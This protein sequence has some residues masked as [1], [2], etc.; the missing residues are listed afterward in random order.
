MLPITNLFSAIPLVG[1][2]IVQWLWGGFSVDNATLNR[3]YSL[4]YLLPFLIAGLVIAHL[5]LLHTNGN[6]NPLINLVSNIDRSL[7][8]LGFPM[9][10]KEY[11]PH[12]TIA[13]IKYPQKKTP[14]VN[15]FLKSTYDPIVFTVDRVQFLASELLKTG[16]IIESFIYL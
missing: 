3:F 12:I 6:T 9:E 5:V 14:D 4:H 8:R 13:R 7:H 16:I 15:L 10:D 2:S 1:D 11:Y